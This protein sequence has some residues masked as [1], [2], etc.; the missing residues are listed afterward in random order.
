MYCFDIYS[1]FSISWAGHAYKLYF[2]LVSVNLRIKQ[3]NVEGLISGA[4]KLTLV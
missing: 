2:R 3:N 1:Y 4:K